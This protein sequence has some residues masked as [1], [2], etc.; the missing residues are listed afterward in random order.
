MFLKDKILDLRGDID[1]LVLGGVVKQMLSADGWVLLPLSQGLEDV[2]ALSINSRFT[3]VPQD[4]CGL[5][6][7]LQA[8]P[9]QVVF[10]LILS[11]SLQ[12]RS[13]F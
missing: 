2:K 1:I 13:Q 6:V 3:S 12:I 11:L 10:Q 9:M 4:R 8:Q 7:Q 5:P